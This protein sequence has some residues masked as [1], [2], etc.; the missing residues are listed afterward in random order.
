MSKASYIENMEKWR[1]AFT[2]FIPVKIRFSETDMFGHV[3]NVSPFIYFEE[4]RI[5][6]LKSIGLFDDDS[7]N[8]AMPIVADLQC[9]YHKQIYFN[10]KLNLYVK[11]NHTGTTSFDIHYMGLNGEDELCL[12]GRGRMVYIKPDTGQPIPLSDAM[13]NSLMAV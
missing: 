11:V 8:G 10:E 3:N 12:T 6:F 13:K 7:N 2:F 4:A 5:E 9:D 1:S